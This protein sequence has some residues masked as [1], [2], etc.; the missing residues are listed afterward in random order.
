[1]FVGKKKSP[2]KNILSQSL[3]DW[4]TPILSFSWKKVKKE[5][6]IE[7]VTTLVVEIDHKRLLMMGTVMVDIG[8]H[9]MN[10]DA[11]S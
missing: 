6:E 5:L 9:V 8:Y 11:H 2:T 3:L 7:L 1:M 4:K 10:T